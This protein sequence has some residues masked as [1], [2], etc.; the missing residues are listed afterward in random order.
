MGLKTELFSFT[1]LLST[2]EWGL[3]MV[4]KPVLGILLLFE[5]TTVQNAF[6]ETQ[7]DLLKPEEIPKN[8]FFMKQKAINACGTI[9]LFHIVLNAKE[10][11]PNIITADSFL[12]KF[13]K[14]ALDKD[15]ESRA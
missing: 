15:P 13:S 9:G 10:K 5:E 1:E 2:E 8:V 3:E 14:N 6:N 7:K 4:P 12:D 11:Y